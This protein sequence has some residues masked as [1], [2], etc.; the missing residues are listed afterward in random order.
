MVG[1]GWRLAGVVWGAAFS[2]AQRAPPA[3]GPIIWGPWSLCPSQPREMRVE[4]P[5]PLGRQDSLSSH[6]GVGR[7]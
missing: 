7:L 4:S 5:Q 2:S 6:A 3:S 1:P